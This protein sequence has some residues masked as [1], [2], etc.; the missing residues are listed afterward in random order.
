MLVAAAAV[1]AHYILLI[2]CHS[3]LIT[4]LLLELIWSAGISQFEAHLCYCIYCRNIQRVPTEEE[5][6][7][8]TVL[9]RK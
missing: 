3:S 4:L 8:I 9:E 1:D 5:E 6:I 7:Q 2:S